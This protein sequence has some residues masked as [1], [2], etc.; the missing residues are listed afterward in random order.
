LRQAVIPR[1]QRT[2]AEAAAVLPRL[3]AELEQRIVIT[4]RKVEQTRRAIAGYDA[5]LRGLV[6]E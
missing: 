2:L 6:G 1:P 5:E 3:Q 4:T